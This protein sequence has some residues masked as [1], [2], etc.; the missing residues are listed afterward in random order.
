MSDKLSVLIVEDVE[1]D[2]LLIVRQLKK[3]WPDLIHRRV[4]SLEELEKAIGATKWDVIIS[5]YNLRTFN[6]LDVLKAVK[7][8]GLDLPFLVVSG[9][10]G[11]ETAVSMMRAGAQD[12]IMKESLNRLAPAIE[13]EVREN[14]FR[15]EHRNLEQSLRKWGQVIMNAHWGVMLIQAGTLEIESA[16]P[17]LEKLYGYGEGELTGEK[18]DILLSPDEKGDL[19]DCIGAITTK[20]HGAMECYHVRKDG[21]VFMV[22]MD[23][24]TLFDDEGKAIYHAIYV[25]D[26]TE[27]NAIQKKI[28]DS[29]AEKEVL[30]SEIHHRV[31]NNL[32]M[33]SS[34]LSLQS[35]QVKDERLTEALRESRQRIKTMALIHEKLYQ[36]GNLARIPLPDYIRKLVD[37]LIGSLSIR[38]QRV[39]LKIDVMD[40]SLDIDTMIPCGLIMNELITNTLKYAFAGV[41]SPELAVSFRFAQDEG[42]EFIVADNGIGLP[43]EVELEKSETLGL[44]LI[45]NLTLQL[46]GTVKVVRGGGTKFIVR[47]PERNRAKDDVPDE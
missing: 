43:G 9:T 37:D 8:R 40:I 22:Q 42:Y 30:L 20:G 36:T 5:D 4:H 35:R 6:G 10:I 46:G 12:Y 31:K 19:S 28:K 29:L 38:G 26:I 18:L 7:G 2:A 47:F 41:A 24:S 21:T 27:R 3:H 13:R 39:T 32:A 14:H 45:R 1:D 11:E 17:A 15:I 25:Q 16:N 33:I 44:M 23:V 34:L